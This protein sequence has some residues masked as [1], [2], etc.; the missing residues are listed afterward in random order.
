MHTIGDRVFA[1]RNSDKEHLYLFGHGVYEG[2]FE[3]VEAAG[4][5]ADTMREIKAETEQVVLNPRIR[6]DSGEAI[7][8]CECWWGSESQFESV[9]RGLTVVPVSIIEAR[10]ALQ[11]EVV[12]SNEEAPDDSRV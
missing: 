4:W 1:V 11:K 8:G 6:L 9:S 5:L 2:E 3:P 12:V 7:Y 10:E